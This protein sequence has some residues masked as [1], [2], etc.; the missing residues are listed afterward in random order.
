MNFIPLGDRINASH[1]YLVEI[2]SATWQKYIV[3][4]AEDS[5]QAREIAKRQGYVV[6]NV[7]LI[8]D[9]PAVFGPNL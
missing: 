4:C 5:L 1:Q 3:V 2:E 7:D 6:R 8:D 9:R